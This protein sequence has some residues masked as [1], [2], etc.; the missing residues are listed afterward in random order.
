VYN[1]LNNLEM[2]D[3]NIVHSLKIKAASAGT[4]L[5]E[6]CRLAG[7]NRQTVEL[8]KRKEPKTITTLRK[9]EEQ[10]AL[11]AMEVKKTK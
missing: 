10:I 8:W 11:K 7:V 9:L 6:V 5:T 4:N 2:S 3:V 1:L